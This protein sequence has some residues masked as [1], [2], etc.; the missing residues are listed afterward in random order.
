V[1]PKRDR[2][3]GRWNAQTG[4]TITEKG[5][6]RITAGPCRGMY[7]HRLLAAYK[8][9]RPLTKD[10]DAH[11]VNGVKLDF[12]FHNIKVLGHQEHGC[13]SAKQHFV[14]EQLDVHL[15]SEWDQ[16]FDSES[17]GGRY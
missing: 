4:S 13:V 6:L 5:Y 10:E 17:G 15:K 8:L 1:K 16:F 9:G 3:T 12:R 14:L 2:K 11:H 7:L